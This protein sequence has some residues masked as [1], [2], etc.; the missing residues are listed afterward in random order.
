PNDLRKLISTRFTDVPLPAV[1]LN[2]DDYFFLLFL[3]K[4]E[5]E[6]KNYPAL[7]L[8]EYP[9]PLAAL[10]TLKSS[11]KRVCERFEIYLDGVEIANAFNELTETQ[12]QK[13][14]FKQQAHEKKQAYQYNL[15]EPT[16][17][18]QTLE[19]GLP[20]CSGIALGVERLLAALIKT[21]NPFFD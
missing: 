17:F 15:P 18:Y 10:S 16:E 5:P 21:P 3:N 4:I 14:R 12:E 11:D 8:Y 2:W 20:K 6:L 13:A 9:A 7:I 19:R 1:E